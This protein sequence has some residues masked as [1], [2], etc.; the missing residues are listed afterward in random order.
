MVN[1]LHLNEQ[2]SEVLLFGPTDAVKLHADL[3]PLPDNSSPGCNWTVI[4]MFRLNQWSWPVFFTC[5]NWPRSNRSFHCIDFNLC[6]YVEPL[7]YYND[8]GLSQSSLNQLQLV[9][10][11]FLLFLTGCKKKKKKLTKTKQNKENKSTLLCF[12]LKALAWSLFSR[13]NLK[14]LWL[15]SSDSHIICPTCSSCTFRHYLRLADP[16]V[17]D[18]VHK[19]LGVSNHCIQTV[20]Q[21]AFAHQAGWLISC[22][23]SS[24]KTLFFL[25]AFSLGS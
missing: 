19:S 6:F 3:S 22:F 24:L 10:N 14:L 25:L 4:L 9:Q 5:D 16:K 13:L 11:A 12:D 17:K 15:F 23:N 21:A 7:D 20:E 2:K 1:I 8:Q 18:K